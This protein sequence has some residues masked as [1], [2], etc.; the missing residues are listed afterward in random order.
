MQLTAQLGGWASAA[1]LAA[2]LVTLKHLE[3]KADVW[4]AP[5]CGFDVRG[6]GPCDARTRGNLTRR[7]WSARTG[8]AGRGTFRWTGPIRQAGRILVGIERRI[9]IGF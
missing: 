1:E 2:K 4:V 5:V 6:R 7:L 8:G 3:P 9:A